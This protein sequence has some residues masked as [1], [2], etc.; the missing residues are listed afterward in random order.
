MHWILQHIPS[1]KKFGTK[2]INKRYYSCIRELLSVLYFIALAW[3]PLLSV[4]Y[5]NVS[6]EL[7][8][9][10]C[11]IVCYHIY[12]GRQ[13]CGRTSQGHTGG[14]SHRVSTPSFCGVCHNFLARRR[15]DRFNSA[16]AN[17]RSLFNLASTWRLLQI[18]VVSSHAAFF[19]A[20][21]ESRNREAHTQKASSRSYPLPVAAVPGVQPSAFSL[22]PNVVFIGAA[23]S[24]R[25]FVVLLLNVSRK[26]RTR[27][28]LLSF[29]Q[30]GG[31]SQNV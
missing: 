23:R 20:E 21:R 27:L 15:R 25:T 22:Q 28:D 16:L 3:C 9:C 5:F 10:V 29:P 17:Q 12:S 8:L 31:K 14:R 7:C 6:W 2:F 1:E 24:F 11:K 26:I 4:I 30:S 19:L 13:A 18:Q